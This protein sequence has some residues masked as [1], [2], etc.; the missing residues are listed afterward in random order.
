MMLTEPASNVSEP[1]DVILTISSTAPRAIEPPPATVDDCADMEWEET[2]VF[3]VILEI[4]ICPLHAD[5]AP[6]L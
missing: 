4:I 2:H 5:D 1:I 6:L 3:D